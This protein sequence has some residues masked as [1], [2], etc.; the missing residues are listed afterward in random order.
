[1]KKT[2]RL[3]KLLETKG[4]MVVPGVYDCLSAKLAERA[5][6]ESITV[7]GA[8]VCASALGYPDFGFITMTE[9][10]Y[11]DRNI[12]RS[13]DIPVFVDCDTGYGNALNV[14]RTVQE[15]EAAGVAGLFF[16]DQ[17]FPKRCG[18]FEGKQ[19]ISEE[20]MVKKI[21]AALDARKDPDL[22][23]MA[24]TDAIATHGLEEAIKRARAY[25]KA[26]AEV[27]FIEAPHT[28][29]DLQRVAKSVD[30]PTMVNLVEGGKTPLIPVQ[31]LEKMGFKLACFSGS[32]QKI[33]ISA[34]QEL[35]T[36]LK[37]TLQV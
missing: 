22:V 13:V 4:I 7:S 27:I 15:F 19:V 6:F 21:Q 31:E 8:G 37:S 23:I 29:E 14:Y 28:R 20:E 24:R 12:A 5:G 16:E 1:M 26:G 34:M 18:H 30:V 9:M 11:Q 35:F 36:T 32:A 3:R 33:A 17:V 10:L 2:T 25:V